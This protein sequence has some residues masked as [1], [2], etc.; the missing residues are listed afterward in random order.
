[1]GPDVRR[2]SSSTDCLFPQEAGVTDSSSLTKSSRGISY[3]RLDAEPYLQPSEVKMVMQHSSSD[4]KGST[5]RGEKDGKRNTGVFLSMRA[6]KRNRIHQVLSKDTALEEEKT[7]KANTLD[8][9]KTHIRS[10]SNPNV[11]EDMVGDSHIHIRAPELPPRNLE[12]PIFTPPHTTPIHTPKKKRDSTLTSL[13]SSVEFTSPMGSDTMWRPP[14]NDKPLPPL[15]DESE[16]PDAMRVRLITSK[17]KNEDGDNISQTSGPFEEIDIVESVQTT[18]QL[19]DQPLGAGVRNSFTISRGNIAPTVHSS[20]SDDEDDQYAEI[21]DFQQY[22][23]MASVTVDKSKT[24]PYKGEDADGSRKKSSASM[25]APLSPNPLPPQGTS[26]M[27]K[28]SHTASAP[29]ISTLRKKLIKSPR[30]SDQHPAA[31]NKDSQSSPPPPLSHHM[32]TPRA[33]VISKTSPNHDSSRPLPPS[34]EKALSRKIS[35]GSNIYEVIDEDFIHRVRNRPSRSNSQREALADWVP[36]VDHSLWPKYLEVVRKF[37]SLPQI[38][39]QW[40]ETVKSIMS[41]VDP[42]DV[43][44]PYSKISSEPHLALAK[45]EDLKE[46]EEEEEDEAIEEEERDSVAPLA[47]LTPHHHYSGHRRPKVLAEK[48]TTTTKSN[49]NPSLHPTTSSSTPTT[50]SSKSPAMDRIMAL[51]AGTGTSPRASPSSAH[52]SPRP[53][54]LTGRRNPPTNSNDLIMMLNQRYDDS[55]SSS[56]ADSDDDDDD[57]EEDDDLDSD[58]SDSDDLIPNNPHL[59]HDTLPPLTDPQPRPQT[60]TKQTPPPEPTMAS[61]EKNPPKIKPKP[62]RVSVPETDLDVALELRASESND[63]DLVSTDSALTKSPHSAGEFDLDRLLCEEP[64]GD[65]E[66]VEVIHNVKPSQFLK[67]K[68]KARLRSRGGSEGSVSSDRS[69][70]DSGNFEA[71]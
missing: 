15:P 7:R 63:S 56:E 59:N 22:M 14:A 21:E 49:K 23:L 28:D 20:D 10:F 9:N 32:G 37:F 39:E 41:D 8:R 40:S 2:R 48:D 46:E 27:R 55:D 17:T 30:S 42:E 53:S 62:R 35:S 19:P 69:C 29:L 54:P 65:S 68:L 60:S 16:T 52:T 33:S 44:P 43:Q 3:D 50:G 58:S 38:Q 57:N 25:T 26:S 34:P 61:R 67:G 13:E 5:P 11:L 1:M 45:E 6:P 18:L 4:Q 36:P 51:A 12:T 64:E 24:F 47:K 70:A 66:G 31:T 71:V